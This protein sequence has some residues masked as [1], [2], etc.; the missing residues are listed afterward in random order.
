M[1][2]QPRSKDPVPYCSHPSLG[3]AR[4]LHSFAKGE[5]TGEQQKALLRWLLHGA[6]RAGGEVMIPGQPDVSAYL[7]GRR[8]V[9]L[10][11]GWVLAQPPEAFR[12]NEID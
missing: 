10:Q 1:A 9:S 11:I 3:E 8:S 4:A 7:A 2:K 12:K 6:S 5:A